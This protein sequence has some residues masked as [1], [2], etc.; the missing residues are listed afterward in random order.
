MKRRRVHKKSYV[1]GA[2]HLFIYIRANYNVIGKNEKK[3]VRALASSNSQNG[4]GSS[5]LCFFGFLFG[6]ALRSFYGA[7]RFSGFSVIPLLRR[8]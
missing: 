2:Q 6:S 7:Q 3:E 5:Y 1:G 8:E 4:T